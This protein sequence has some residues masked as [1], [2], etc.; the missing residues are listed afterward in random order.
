M[1][2][3]KSRKK[4]AS[5]FI[6]NQGWV[7]LCQPSFAVQNAVGHVFGHVYP[8]KGATKNNLMLFL[9]PRALAFQQPEQLGE[10]DGRKTPADYSQQLRLVAAE[11]QLEFS[12]FMHH[13]L[14]G[15]TFE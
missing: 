5:K 11:A 4:K 8:K 6:S 9:S 7:H 3:K 1:T 13:F 10:T 12:W 15:A 2:P 14:V